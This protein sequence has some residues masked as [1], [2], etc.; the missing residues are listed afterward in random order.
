MSML[1]HFF[2]FFYKGKGEGGL[3][4]FLRDQG[5]RNAC[6]M[7]LHVSYSQLASHP[8]T[9]ECVAVLIGLYTLTPLRNKTQN[10]LK[11]MAILSWH[12]LTLDPLYPPREIREYCMH[13]NISCYTVSALDS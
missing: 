13:A 7:I 4:W 10:I 1:K 3:K 6:M 2:F 12:C 9:K 8:E 5:F 11:Y